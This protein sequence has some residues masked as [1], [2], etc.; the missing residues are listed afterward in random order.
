MANS[1]KPDVIVA[2][3]GGSPMDAAKIMWV[4]YEHRIPRSKTWPCASWTSA[5]VSTSSRKWA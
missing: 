4:M 2:L 3:G 5:S 1:F